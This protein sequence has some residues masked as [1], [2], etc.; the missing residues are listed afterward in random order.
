MRKSIILLLTVGGLAIAGAVDAATVRSA[1]LT[2]RILFN[3]GTDTV[4]V[5]FGT[6]RIPFRAADFKSGDSVRFVFDDTSGGRQTLWLF[7]RTDTLGI[8]ALDTAVDV[9]LIAG[10][11]T[12]L[13]RYVLFPQQ[14]P[15]HFLYLIEQYASFSGVTTKPSLN[16]TYAAASQPALD[17]LRGGLQL[18]SIAGAGD[19]LSRIIN[20]MH[21]VHTTVRHD[22]GAL[23]PPNYRVADLLASAPQRH[24]GVNCGMLTDIMNEVYLAAGF[25]SRRVVCLPYDTT[26][27]ECHSICAVWSTT[28]GK[29][30]Y[31]DPT[32]EGMFRDTAGHYLSIAEVRK[33]M[34]NK[35]SLIV[36]EDLNW[37][38]QPKARAEYLWYM[39]KNLFRFSC[40]S[41]SGPPDK[42]VRDTMYWVFLSPTGYIS[43]SKER[44]DPAGRLTPVVIDDA[45][46]F[47][48]APMYNESKHEN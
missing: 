8:L 48:R 47:W 17:S 27:T 22:G 5:V 44:I 25:V 12:V 19:E 20:L 18:D 14:P 42:N 9:N 45:D 35:D 6:D 33:A 34:A 39:A 29:W 26:D 36:S 10:N 28:F 2:D 11:D 30:L 24:T 4:T 3:T 32:F 46:L 1:R 16:F 41:H 21:W 23:P 40:V 38:G 15:S 7:A 13:T 31:V 37:N 43:A